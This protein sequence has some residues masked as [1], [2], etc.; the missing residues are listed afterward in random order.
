[1]LV[2]HSDD[3]D[4]ADQSIVYVP[5]RDCPRGSQRP[6]FA[7]AVPVGDQPAFNAVLVPRLVNM[8][9]EDELR[10]GTCQGI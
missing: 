7:S 3:N 9:G 6:V 2:S 1:M 5:A 8:A 10:Q 4:L